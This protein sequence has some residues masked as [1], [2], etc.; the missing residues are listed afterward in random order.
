[1][2][3]VPIIFLLQLSLIPFYIFLIPEGSL[4]G[5]VITII[6]VALNA[7]LGTPRSFTTLSYTP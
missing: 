5:L 4:I 1:M 6:S 2:D 3:P 7:V